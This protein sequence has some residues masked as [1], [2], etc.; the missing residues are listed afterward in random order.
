MKLTIDLSPLEESNIR[1][2][3]NKGLAE[4]EFAEHPYR[5]VLEERTRARF[6]QIAAQFA[7]PPAPSP[8]P[9]DPAQSIRYRATTF[10]KW[11]AWKLATSAELDAMK[12]E[13]G[14][15][16]VSQLVNFYGESGGGGISVQGGMGS[17]GI[18]FFWALVNGVEMK[19]RDINGAADA[20]IAQMAA[21][22]G[23]TVPASPI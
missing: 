23:R 3:V 21:Q 16:P 5:L 12:A 15:T 1:G 20:Y 18:P 4:P 8:V 14:V 2:W 7:V 9:T 6:E 17:D 11:A 22:Q 10:G 13:F 19:V